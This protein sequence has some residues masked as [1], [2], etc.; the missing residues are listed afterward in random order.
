MYCGEQELVCVANPKS[1]MARCK[2]WRPPAGGGGAGHCEKCHEFAEDWIG[3]S[4]GGLCRILYSRAS[5]SL[6]S[7]LGAPCSRY[8]EIFPLRVSVDG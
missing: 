3:G 2:A 1:P 5:L 7:I 8:I 4:I 6:R